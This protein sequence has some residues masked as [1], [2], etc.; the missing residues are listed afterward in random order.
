[1]TIGGGS[2]C[3]NALNSNMK[4]KNWKLAA[5]FYVFA[6]LTGCANDIAQTT[7]NVPTIPLEQ[8]INHCLASLA[9]QGGPMPTQN[10][11]T[12]SQWIGYVTC[13]MSSN[14]RV[15]IDQVHENPEATVEI[16]INND[17]SINSVKRLRTSGSEAWDR[18]VDIS[19]R[20]APPLAPAPT[21]RHFS[22][23]D[24]IFT[25]FSQGGGMSRGATLTGQSH[26]SMHQCTSTGGA[27]ACN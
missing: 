24:L 11:L 13:A 21:E 18:A 1:M 9:P 5:C 7:S 2:F 26:W 12:A 3:I 27:V 8:V 10:N 16:L 15:D 20:A 23:L 19:I 17:G 25:P 22:K 6:Q 14:L 4:K